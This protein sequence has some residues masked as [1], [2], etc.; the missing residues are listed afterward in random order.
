MRIAKDVITEWRRHIHMHPEISGEE[1][2]TAVYIAGLLREFGLEVT[3]G[4]GGYGVV[5]LL[6]G[7]DAYKCAALRADMDA[8]PITE[9]SR[10][11]YKSQA[12]GAM[13]ACGHD[14]HCAIVLGAAKMLAAQPPPGSVKFIF[15]PHEEQKPGGARAMIAAGVLQQ[16][17]VDGIFAGHV[18]NLFPAGTFAV[19]DGAMMAASD[20]F[21]LTLIGHGGH[22]AMPHQTVDVIA[23]AAQ[24]IEA[25]QSIRSR[26][27]DPLEPVVLTVGSIHGG[28]AHN[29]IPDRVDMTG[30]L[31]CFDLALRD[32]IVAYMEESIR[33]ITHSWGAT[34]EFKM[35][36]GYPPVINDH[37]LTLL[38]DQVVQQ[39]SGTMLND[40]PRPL[41][42]GEDFAV[43]G[44]Q[45]PAAFVFIGT[46][47]D[48]CR[49]PWHHH[50]FDIEECALPAAAQ[51]LALAAQQ[52]A[53]QK[54]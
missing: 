40:H 49:E 21:E 31:R 11:R 30:T 51:V 14:A 24:I 12:A 35:I 36:Y 1:H 2:D 4:V 9:I 37:Q 15:Q 46:G 52:L 54:K 13:H 42:A 29:I 28:S 39:V 25:L 26:R 23:I 43:Y 53:G 18:T 10:R 38:L 7:D 32:Q 47:S 6:R 17:Q 27:V 8:L 16:P 50:S 34:Y 20:N 45:V 22:G 3:E 33:D 44:Q 19:N 41:T 5:G 48:K